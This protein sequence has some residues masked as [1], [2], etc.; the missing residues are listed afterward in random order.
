MS[1]QAS[2]GRGRRRAGR[3]LGLGLAA[4]LL[5][6]TLAA[7]EAAAEILQPE[8]REAVNQA[9][10]AAE[11]GEWQRAFRL[12]DEV[13][14]PLPGKTLGWL[15]MVEGDSPADFATAANFL[16]A[17]PDWPLAERLQEFAEDRIVDPAD[18][19]LI[20]RFFTAYEPL[21]T[22]GH[23]RYAEA[24]LDIGEKAR[25]RA[26]IRR[27]WVDGDFSR[28]EE[29]RF[30][31]KY[32]RFLTQDDS[33]ARLDNLLWDHRRASATRM[34]GRVP[35]GYRRLAEARLRLQRRQNGLDKAIEAVPAEL[36]DDPGLVFDRLRWRRQK[37]RHAGV[38]ELLLDP[39]AELGRP[40]LW[41]FE[42]E[43]QIRRALRRRNFD[44]A[45]R[46]ASRHAQTEGEDF[47]D[48]EWLAGWLAL[49]HAH[50]PDTA[51]RHFVRMHDGAEGPLDQSKAAYWAG[52]SASALGDRPLASQW[53]HAAA[54]SQ[55]AY[56]GQLA[57]EELGERPGPLLG[58]QAPSPAERTAFEGK[59][60]VRVVRMLIAAG[61][62]DEAAPFLLELAGEATSPAEVGLI[63]DLAASSGRPYLV[64]QLGRYAAYYGQV[65]AAAAFP[66]PDLERMLRPAQGG[67]EAAL[68][69]GMARQESVFNSW[70]E[71]SAGAGG[72]L[73]LMPRTAFLMARA[74]GLPYNH[75]LLTGDP[76]YNIRLA[77]HY[78]K[79]LLQRYGGNVALV[80]AAYNAGP[81][82][83]DE[84]LRLHGD[85]RRG[86][87]YD[88]V[89]WVELI[90]FDETRNYVKRVLEGR[91][92]Y[93]RRLA[94]QNLQTVWFKPINGPLDPLPAP[95]LKSPQDARD[96]EVAELVA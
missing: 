3:W 93:R 2:V 88:L 38:V 95:L 80:V 55:I 79:T 94:D 92:M 46:L 61:V 33:I 24:L 58:S 69:L 19:E 13:E 30:Y 71:S 49:R 60:T 47:V 78:L 4:F 26:L 85:P 77:S 15:R 8:D 37:G 29:R 84:W 25:A 41:W 39:P 70:V 83:V 90:P 43:H 91:N 68:L 35:L 17:N 63:A 73:Q 51:F 11:R 75:G 48:A 40:G 57:A 18:H 10:R 20:R 59:E 64:G 81:T 45:Y 22:R 36:R 52:R 56:Y 74:M 32:R 7:A 27:A 67:P 89:D 16:L 53:Y 54:R 76:D 44:L 82:R 21:T 14:D 66:V 6:A 50:E 1:E 9:F 42:R 12:L 31:A 86:N 62:E 28:R 23:I 34:L 87:R 65:N 5:S 72:L 96:A